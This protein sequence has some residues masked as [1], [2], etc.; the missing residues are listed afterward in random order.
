MVHGFPHD[1]HA[2]T[3][4]GKSME[5]RVQVRSRPRVN[6]LDV[7]KSQRVKAPHQC[8]SIECYSDVRLPSQQAW[9]VLAV[10][11]VN[12]IDIVNL[13]KY[14]YGSQNGQ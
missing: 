14:A 8:Y 4:V 12:P 9:T 6:L 13:H 10:Y 11:D 5:H 1:G 3:F 7:K 2:V